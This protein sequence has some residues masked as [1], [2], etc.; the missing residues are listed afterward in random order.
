MTTQIAIRLPDELVSRLDSLV[1][2]VHETRTDA[3]RRSVELYL[4]RLA[5]ERDADRYASEPLT[6]NELA[7]ADDPESW[8][9][10]PP[11]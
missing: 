11:W 3:I 10:T 7:I 6:D 5:C 9:G 1:P 2:A 8:A 4:Y